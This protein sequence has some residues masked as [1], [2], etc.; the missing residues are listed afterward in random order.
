MCS[1]RMGV[2][3]FCFQRFFTG[4]T[5]VCGRGDLGTEGLTEGTVAVTSVRSGGDD[6]AVFT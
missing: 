5:G 1:Q 3:S 6:G 4:A 2:A